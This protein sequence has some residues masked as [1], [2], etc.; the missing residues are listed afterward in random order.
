[1]PMFLG[2]FVAST[3]ARSRTF[4]QVVQFKRDAEAVLADV[5]EV[6]SS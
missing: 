1:M 5:P 6:P 4:S 3:A 2:V